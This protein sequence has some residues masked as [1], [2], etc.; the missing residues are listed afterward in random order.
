VFAAAN[1]QLFGITRGEYEGRLDVQFYLPKH[2]ALERHMKSCGFPVHRVGSAAI[3]TQVVDGPFGSDLKVDEYVPE[4]VPLLRVSNCRTGR[5]QI[6]DEMVFI[7]EAKHAELIRSEV[8]PGDVLLTKAGAILGYSAVFPAE[9]KRGNITSHLASIRPAEGV[10]PGYL[11]EF[12]TSSIGIQQIYRWGNKS[13][14]PE[15][16]TDEVRAIEVVLP[17]PVKQ[18]ELTAAMDAARAVWRVKLAEADA[19]FDGLDGFLIATLGLNPPPKNDRKVFAVKYKALQE[20]FDP[21]TYLY[22]PYTTEKAFPYTSLGSLTVTEPD[23]GS[24]S[25]AVERTSDD[26]PKYI[27]ITDFQDEGIPH[28]HEFVT[29]ETIEPECFLRD[30]DILFA[31]SGA[32]AGKTFIYT[33][34]IGPAVF[35]G[36]CIRFRFDESRVLPRFVY[37]FT[38]TA[39]YRQW[40]ATI[41]R[42][43]GQPNINKPEFKSLELP[44]PPLDIQREV[45]ARLNAERKKIEALRA[46]AEGGWQAAKRWFEEQLLGGP[47]L[48]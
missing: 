28:G 16:N 5:I 41:Q 43:S 30:G 17:P 45:V 2:R 26:Q 29:A 27:R 22:R 25:R 3:S 37:Y 39:A 15:L 20:R 1:Q 12:L 47:V 9:L 6:D 10:E 11:S 44:I 4:G 33:Q 13:T 42:P 21:K 32:T 14:R 36:Y 23:Y 48:Q 35:G 38:K 7:T 31:R 18:R 24:G 8:L 34:D 46:E 19:L 40:V